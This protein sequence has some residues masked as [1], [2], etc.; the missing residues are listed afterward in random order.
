MF[1]RTFAVLIRSLYRALSLI[2]L[3]PLAVQG[4][5]VQAKS[6]SPCPKKVIS[7][8]KGS[9]YLYNLDR[10]VTVT[11]RKVGG[12]S[13]LA[14]PGHK[15]ARVLEA[16]PS[17][18]DQ[19]AQVGSHF[20]VAQDW[21]KQ[22][23]V[24]FWYHGNKTGKPVTV[25]ILGQQ[26]PDPGPDAW[27]LTWSDE[28]NGAAGSPPDPSKWN[29]D[30]GNNG[31]WGNHELE[32]YTDST[33]NAALDGNGNL[34]ITAR[35]APAN[36]T[37]G[38]SYGTCLYTSARLLT[39]GHAEF[40][41]GRIEAR[42]K[43]PAQEPGLWPA[44]W[45]LGSNISTVGWPQSGEIDA[46][47]NVGRLPGQIFGTAH[48]PVSGGTGNGGTYTLPPDQYDSFHT[49]TIDWFPDKIIW[50]VDGVKYHEVDKSTAGSDWVYNHPFFI[51]L[52]L[53]IGGDFGGPVGANTTFPQSMTVDY[54]RVYQ[55]PDTA[56]RFAA[57]FSDT[58]HGWKRITIPYSAFTRASDQPANAPTSPLD[59]KAIWGWA[60]QVPGGYGKP[61]L[62]A[63]LAHEKVTKRCK[64]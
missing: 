47:E 6:K 40:Q 33:D 28:F 24:S 58:F 10:N 4:S 48:G 36:N 35:K 46:M 63:G 13:S 57:T 41:Y 26:A 54:V 62:I 16:T 43:L 3:L 7:N 61:M 39:Q 55:A 11:S 2:L 23:A 14:L 20:D 9:A 49:Y 17:S 18:P 8:F 38:C 56:E 5:G 27:P 44:F 34:V 52:N 59:T 19:A 15:G 12:H 32:Y 53:A 64:P 42:I 37:L 60:I 29:H 50:Y 1:H 31:G 45:T 30:T 22:N 51:L 21:S 25:Q